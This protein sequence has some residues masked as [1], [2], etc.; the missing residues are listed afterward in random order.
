MGLGQRCC[1]AALAGTV[2]VLASAAAPEPRGR[3]ARDDV[4]V[5]AA[6]AVR[7]TPRTVP[8]RGPQP[9]PAQ[10]GAVTDPAWELVDEIHL[11]ERVPLGDRAAVRFDAAAEILSEVAPAPGIT[12]LAAQAVQRAPTWL[13]HELEDLFARLP[14]ARQDELA[15]VILDAADPYVDEIA[16]EVAHLA[17]QDLQNGSFFTSLITDNAHWLYSIDADVD[18]AEIVDYGSAAAGGDYYSTIRYRVEEDGVPATYELPR[19]IYYWYVVHPRGSD[20]LPTYI[21]P[22][23]PC[24]SGGTPAAPPTGRFWRDW[25][26]YGATNSQGG[27]CDND[28]DGAIDGPCPVL[29]DMLAGVTVLWKGLRDVS[30]AANGAV[31]VVTEWVRRSLGKFGDRDGCRPIQ[32]VTIYYWMDGNCGEWGDLTMAAARAALIPTIVI[33]AAVNDH[34][35]NEFY[36]RRWVQWEPTNNFIDHPDAYDSWWSSHGGM[37]SCH[38]WRG[39]GFGWSDETALYTPSAT[40]TVNVVDANGYPVDGARVKL[41][42]ELDAFPLLLNTITQGHT[43]DSGQV[44]FTIGDHRNFYVSVHTPWGDYPSSGAAEAVH[45]AV[46]GTSY[47]YDVPP[48]PGT[49]PRVDVSSAPPPPDPIDDHMLEIDYSVDGELL[50]GDGYSTGIEYCRH[51]SPGNVDFFIADD[52]N[53]SQF[54]SG[55]ACEAHEIAL[56]SAGGYLQFVVPDAGDWYVV[57]A[58]KAG[59]DLGQ[60]LAA[61]VRLYRNTGAVPPVEHLTVDRDGFASLLD[62]EDVVGQNVDGYNVYRSTNPADVG[63]DRTEGE[64]APFLLAQTATS[65]YRDPEAAPTGTCFFYS[66][67]TRSKRG[68][69]SP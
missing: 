26:F 68:G 24:S 30:G 36:E 54:E 31:G 9:S 56:D 52:P 4:P 32:P 62:W 14:S 20:E 51:L 39:D 53:W 33:D 18:Y 67:R 41:L 22:A 12:S 25:L 19:D 8:P 65:D 34:C 58:N 29:R 50:H 55:S 44:T 57:F 5:P 40:L 43:D 46:A 16:F 13:Q 49:V 1:L 66:V 64:L 45:D 17:P 60:L 7:G 15:N 28:R 69:I 27:Q 63:K 38:A 59:M 2:L 47:T 21:D 23:A 37:A 35:W 3:T 42:S 11:D 6:R 10:G 48:F 61:T